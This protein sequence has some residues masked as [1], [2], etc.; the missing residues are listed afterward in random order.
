MSLILSGTD[1]LSDIDGTAATPAI[2]GTDANTGIFFPAA[3]TIAF[4]EGGAEAMR[5][6]S[7]GNVGIGNT[8]PSS[9]D[10]TG[11]NLVVG[12]GTGNQGTT[13]YAGTT[14]YA[15]I[16]FADGTS[17][18]AAYA[19]QISYYH[20]DNAL[21]FATNTGAERM[22]IDSS[23]NV[24]IGTASP[25]VK[26]HVS[27]GTQRIQSTG[28]T[29]NAFLTLQNDVG[30]QAI[31]GIVSSGNSPANNFYIETNAGKTVY[32]DT[33]GQLILKR[34]AAVNAASFVCSATQNTRAVSFVNNNNNNEVGYIFLN[35][36]GTTTQYASSSD[37]RLK[38]NI[39]P[40]TDALSVVA[41]LKP[42][43]YKWKINGADGQGFIAHELQAVI[44][45]CVTGEKDD[46]ETY[47]DENG[48]E[49]KRPRYQGVD[50]SFLVATLTAAIQEQQTLITALTARITAL[51][52]AP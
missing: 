36:D 15:S 28:S 45:D 27:G 33:G 34:T 46:V 3:D 1:G 29:S 20:T 50:T 32:V 7:S 43:K 5:I 51:E 37:Y 49:Q 17:G 6:D 16:N 4:S 48:N 41:Q 9:F 23:G 30:T 14:G 19:G 52:T 39:V 38:E 18:S 8:T 24:G 11:R 10:A 21:L 13:I 47:T 40:M 42:V 44:P 12:S 35:N 22:R 31:L 25:A 2:R 26:L